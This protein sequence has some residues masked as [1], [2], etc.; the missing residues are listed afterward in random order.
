MSVPSLVSLTSQVLARFSYGLQSLENIPEELILKIISE[1]DSGSSLMFVELASDKENW[2]NQDRWKEFS[3]MNWNEEKI[4]KVMGIKKK[5]K[6]ES[7]IN[8]KFKKS[9]KTKKNTI[10]KPPP[11]IVHSFL[12]TMPTVHPI[13]FI[14]KTF[15]SPGF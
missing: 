4:K 10:I 12:R 13:N 7:K 11:T 1:C 5:K 14:G 15:S 6:R 2:E 9:K 3:Q 8:F